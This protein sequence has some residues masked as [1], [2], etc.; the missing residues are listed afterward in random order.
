MKLFFA[1]AFL[2]SGLVFADGPLV[3]GFNL[4]DNDLIK[5]DSAETETDPKT[6]AQ[7]AVDHA[8]R[9]GANHIILNVRAIMKGGHGN[10]IIPMTAPADRNS[11]LKRMLRLSKYIKSLGMSVGI[12]PIFFVFGPNGEFPYIEKLPDGSTKLWWHG[13]IQPQDPNRWFESFRVFLDVYLTLAK[14]GKFEE[15]TIGAEL[16]SMTVG[17]EDQWKEYPYG[18]PG[19]W[20]ELL[21]Y[22]RKALPTAR[23]MYDI[24]FTDDSVGN[25]GLTASGGELERWRYRLVDLADRTQ[26]EEQKIWNEFASFWKELDAIGIDMYRSLANSAEKFPTDPS[27]L[28]AKLRERTD[29]FATQMDNTMTQISLTLE[30]EK[31]VIFKEIGFRSVDQGFIDPF[32]YAG[33]GTVNLVHQASAMKALLESF[34]DPKWPWFQGINFWE[35]SLSPEKLGPEDDGF[36]P[37]GKPLSEEIISKYYKN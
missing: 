21:R 14:L 33:A 2:F 28:T 36:S 16:Y 30:V 18:F 1:I 27:E 22:V 5:Y 10:E 17:V 35:I 11:E 20:L 37:V 8:K 34:W 25:S 19:R 31:P 15:F 29:S 6:P 32:S 4:V 13:N 26:P 3:R 12:R 24:N 23:L 9:L 7:I